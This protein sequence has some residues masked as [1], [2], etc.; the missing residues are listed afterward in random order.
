MKALTRVSF[1]AWVDLDETGGQDDEEF[2][3]GLEWLHLRDSMVSI[4][5]NIVD[6]TIK[7]AIIFN[8]SPAPSNEYVPGYDTHPDWCGMCDGGYTNDGSF[9]SC[10]VG[11]EANANDPAPPANGPTL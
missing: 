9:C 4:A 2:V 1:L 10:P 6:G 3:S 11:T 8:T 5:G 7:A